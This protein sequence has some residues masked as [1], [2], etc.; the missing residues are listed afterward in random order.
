MNGFYCL[1]SQQGGETTKTSSSGRHVTM[2]LSP[3]RNSLC[4]FI[5]LLNPF[6]AVKLRSILEKSEIEMNEPLLARTNPCGRIDPV[7][8]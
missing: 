6:R 5:P 3:L 7:N 1:A 8:G 4:F 2:D